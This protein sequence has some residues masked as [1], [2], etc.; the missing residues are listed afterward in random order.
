MKS[1]LIGFMGAPGSG[2]TI[3][4]C[5]LKEY[6]MLKK[7]STDV[8]TEYAREF[9]FKYGIPKHP[10]TQYR[11]TNEQI[12]KEELLLKGN[13]EYIFTDSPIWLGY[14]FNLV[15]M[16][17]DYDHEIRTSLNDMY[18]KFVVDQMHRYYI[19]F[20]VKNDNP[21]NDGCR[22]MEINKK[23][24]NIINGFVLSHKHILPIVDIDI[25]I[26]N[27]LERKDFV[28]KTLEEMKK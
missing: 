11:V 15:N 21:F 14:I 24:A 2:K 22:D 1:K 13:S 18:D 28:W 23:I 17:S 20:H 26:E 25:P 4:A 19:V 10:Y 9:C 6:F 27:A 16:K 8:C 12:D 5:A 3:L 7:I